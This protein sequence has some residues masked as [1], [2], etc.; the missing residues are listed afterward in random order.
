[1]IVIVS[2]GAKLSCAEQSSSSLDSIFI[3]SQR[4]PSS[5]YNGSLAMVKKQK[6]ETPNV[7]STA[8]RDIVQRLNFLYQA[9]VYLQSI[10]PPPS[11]TTTEHDEART[12]NSNMGEGS[13]TVQS[14]TKRVKKRS[15]RRNVSKKGTS[16]LARSYVQCMHV[17]GQKTTVKM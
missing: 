5:S 1:M 17:V 16:D 14:T 2:G 6:E 7:N 10:A 3:K 13:S 11:V 9:S 12:L 4:Y 15:K 8:N